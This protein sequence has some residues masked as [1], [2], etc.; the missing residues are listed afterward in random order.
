[1]RPVEVALTE[2]LVAFLA[3]RDSRALEAGRNRAR[4]SFTASVSRSRRCWANP[5]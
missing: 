2:F 4:R 5:I 3:D 1:L